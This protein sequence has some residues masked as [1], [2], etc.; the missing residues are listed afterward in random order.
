VY[1][2]VGEKELSRSKA[3]TVAGEPRLSHNQ[4]E[5][6]P[7]A[8][9]MSSTVIPRREETRKGAVAQE[10]ARP[11]GFSRNLTEPVRVRLLRP[12][13]KR[14]CAPT[15]AERAEPWAGNFLTPRG[16]ESTLTVYTHGLTRCRRADG[17]E[18][19]SRPWFSQGSPP[20]PR[21][22]L[23]LWILLFSSRTINSG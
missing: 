11:C 22:G 3:G 12:L 9:P 21:W 13:L 7:C 17:C 15:V 16:W 5:A 2:S 10:E 18:R 4:V 20:P 14:R 23:A 1:L 6:G 19:T 8:A